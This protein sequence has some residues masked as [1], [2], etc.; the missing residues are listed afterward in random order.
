[1]LRHAARIGE[2]QASVFLII[3]IILALFVVPESWRVPV[4]A[5]GALVEVVETGIEVWWSRRARIKFGPETLIG[6]SGIVTAACRPDGL[7]RVRGE[8]WQAR[9]DEG[10]DVHQTIVVLGRDRLTLEVR[11]V[12]DAD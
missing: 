12:A 8:V 10:A 11:V 4:I 3:A 9:C 6:A 1:M 5:V 7:V 2:N